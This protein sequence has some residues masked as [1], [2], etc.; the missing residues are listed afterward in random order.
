MIYDDWE[1]IYQYGWS[2]QGL[3]MKRYNSSF[4]SLPKAKCYHFAKTYGGQR[5]FEVNSACSKYENLGSTITPKAQ[6]GWTSYFVCRL[7]LVSVITLIE[8]CGGKITF[9][10]QHSEKSE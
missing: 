8:I 6:H 5:T 10:G 4:D 3:G 2:K 9:W 1:N 7:S